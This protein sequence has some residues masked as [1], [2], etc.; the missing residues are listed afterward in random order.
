LARQKK[1][2]PKNFIDSF[3]LSDTDAV[4][5]INENVELQE[6]VKP[7]KGPANHE[8][9]LNPISGEYLPKAAG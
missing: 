1:K 9:I 7:K 2:K 8:K 4:G 6:K 3:V 5:Q